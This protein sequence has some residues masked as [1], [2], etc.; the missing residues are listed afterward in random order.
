MQDKLLREFHTQSGNAYSPHLLALLLLPGSVHL[1]NAEFKL[2]GARGNMYESKVDGTVMNH[3]QGS[4]SVLSVKEMNVVYIS[5]NAEYQAYFL[6]RCST[7]GYRAVWKRGYE[8]DSGPDRV[9]L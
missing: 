8:H 7:S 6:L 4:P 5:A 3:S 2:G 1:G 9:V